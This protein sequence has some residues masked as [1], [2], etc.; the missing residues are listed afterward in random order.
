MPAFH[1]K[2]NW[3]REIHSGLIARRFKPLASSHLKVDIRHL[4]STCVITHELFTA[5]YAK[6][7][8]ITHG[9]QLQSRIKFL[10]THSLATGNLGFHFDGDGFGGK[11]HISYG[12]GDALLC[13]V[14]IKDLLKVNPDGPASGFVEGRDG[15]LVSLVDLIGPFYIIT[16]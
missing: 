1:E 16:N 3:S 12:K 10:L 11:R 14:R 5:A 15:H 4:V 13:G 7:Q 6:I 8:T 9:L 2:A